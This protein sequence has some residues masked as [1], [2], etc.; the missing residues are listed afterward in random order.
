[1]GKNQKLIYWLETNYS[2]YLDS[3]SLRS[4]SL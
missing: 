4:L 3:F 2:L 1:V